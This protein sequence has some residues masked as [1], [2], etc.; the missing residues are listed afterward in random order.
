V[1][2]LMAIMFPRLGRQPTIPI[3]HRVSGRRG[4]NS[5]TADPPWKAWGQPWRRAQLGEQ[6]AS[7]ASTPK[8]LVDPTQ[9]YRLLEA[10]NASQRSSR[11]GSVLNVCC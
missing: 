2:R 10:R 11:W 8:L 1:A 9:S 6:V 7:A 4:E 3:V 5:Q